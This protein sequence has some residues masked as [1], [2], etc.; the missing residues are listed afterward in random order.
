MSELGSETDL[1]WGKREKKE[2]KLNHK[3]AKTMGLLDSCSY[4]LFVIIFPEKKKQQKQPNPNKQQNK[5]TNYVDIVLLNKQTSMC[6]PCSLTA[7]ALGRLKFS[8]WEINPS[9]D[10]FPLSVQSV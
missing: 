4:S 9:F 7:R 10:V 5:P 3:N 2:Q 6:G 8:F 1:V